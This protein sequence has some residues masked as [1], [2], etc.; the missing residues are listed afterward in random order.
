[1]TEAAQ[2][3][4]QNRYIWMKTFWSW[5]TLL[6]PYQG[7]NIVGKMTNVKKVTWQRKLKIIPLTK[8]SSK[9]DWKGPR[10]WGKTKRRSSDGRDTSRRCGDQSSWPCPFHDT[11]SNLDFQSRD[12]IADENHLLSAE[13]GER[14]DQKPSSRYTSMQMKPRGGVI[15]ALESIFHL[16]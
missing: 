11:R 15:D 2:H 16:L 8:R 9:E 3:W 10:G 4:N 12:M 5:C 13:L 14:R 1:M 6:I 7:W